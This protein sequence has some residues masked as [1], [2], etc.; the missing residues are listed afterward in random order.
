MKNITNVSKMKNCTWCN[1]NG[2]FCSSPHIYIFSNSSVSCPCCGLYDFLN[3]S[4]I[5]CIT[6][7]EF[8]FNEQYKYDIRYKYRYCN[9]CK[10]L[11]DIGCVHY[12]GGLMSYVF[13]SHFIKKWKHND[14]SIVYEGMPEFDDEDDWLNNANNI[15]ILE[16]NC[17]HN[18]EKCIN[19][20]YNNNFRCELCN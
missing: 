9:H 20:F 11:F 18:N 13:N 16:L 4:R 12:V 19:T 10:I 5:N 6:K 8:L 3:M 2:Y 1:K 17:P 14:S 15:T 7:Y